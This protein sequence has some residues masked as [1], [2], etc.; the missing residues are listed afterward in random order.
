MGTVGTPGSLLC[1]DPGSP[2]TYGSG[3][4]SVTRRDR[5]KGGFLLTVVA[6]FTLDVRHDVTL[7]P[8]SILSVISAPTGPPSGDDGGRMGGRVSR[9]FTFGSGL[10][11]R[12]TRVEMRP[13]IH[14]PLVAHAVA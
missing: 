14:F 1:H 13:G 11:T 8:S 4:T 9:P 6:F 7:S 3:D 2:F 5:V 10:T 12:P